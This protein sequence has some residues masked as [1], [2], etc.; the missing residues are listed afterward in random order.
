MRP[1]LLRLFFFCIIPIAISAQDSTSVVAKRTY[2]TRPLISEKPPV[3]DGTLDDEAWHLAKWAGEFIEWQP[4]ENTLPSQQ[5][6]FKIL[7]DK[8]FLYVA[9][10]CYDSEPKKIEKRLTRRD[11]FAG[12]RIAIVIDSYHDKRTAF[13]F[14]TTVAGVKGDEFVSENGNN[15][16]NSWNPIWFTATNIDSEGWTGE[17]KIP[18]SQLKFGKAEEQV[19]G[20]QV[21][22]LLFREEE[23]SVW[24]RT[25]LDAAGFVSEFGEL[26]GLLNIEPQKQLEIQPFTV[27]Q[28]DSY[29]LE[30]GNPFRD[31]SDYG[32]NV[33]LDAKIGI[34]NDLTL[35]LTVNPDFGQVDADPGAIALD[36]FQIFFQ[37]RRP[38]FVENKN[39]FDFEFANGNDNVFYS[40][41]I[42]RDP[43]GSPDLLDGE[44]SDIPG[45]TTIL[46]AAKFSGKTKNGWSVGLLESVTGKMYAEIDTDGERREELVEP[47]T[48]YLVGRLQKDFNDRN[49]YIGGI[50]TATNRSLQ[51]NLDFL[52]SAAYT[53]GFDFKHNWKDRNYYIEG[54]LV[55]SHVQGSEEAIRRTQESITHLFQRVDASHVT[56]DPTRTSLTGTGGKIEFGKAG[57]G[58]WRYEG[59]LIWRSPELELND[60][61]FLRQADEIRQYTELERL[62]L[63]PTKLYRRARIG[64][65]QFTTYDFEGNFNRIQY[66]LSGYINFMN[67]WALEGGGAHKPRIFSNTVLRGGP[68]WQWSQE[69]FAY[70]FIRSDTR[71]K[72][73]FALGYIKSQARQNNFSLTRYIMEL[74]YQPFDAFNFSLEMEYEENPNKTQY[75]TTA[76]NGDTTRYILGAIDQKTFSTSIRFNYSINPNLSIQYYGQPFISRGTYTD[77]NYV[78][79]PIAY[80]LS[81][82]VMLY[83]PNQISLSNSVYGI[84]ENIDGSVDYTFNNPD[85]AF[86]QFRSNLVVRWEYIPGSEVFFVWSQG[87]TGFG[88]PMDSLS[89]SLDDQIFGQKPENTFLI[90][91]TYRF[92]L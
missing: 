66:Q 28:F 68:R 56:V 25:P 36:G 86:V 13:S 39:I 2:T 62:F 71:K 69:N 15:W 9:Y 18:F 12:D 19:W 72:F 22:R 38:F 84:D 82:R 80:D 42:G 27:N 5:T 31:G 74:N 77:F 46:G 4:D 92:V 17:A 44:F 53:G 40:R 57:G 33:G 63:E 91:A 35:D 78:N 52:R 10:R 23:R 79:N 61:G 32:F 64:I 30:S 41:R 65:E 58:N 76:D 81:E 7:Y 16:D 54:N 85:F 29:P 11:G 24:N 88:D 20:L 73:N 87:V 60:V 83:S 89:S 45:N 49:S 21:T 67:N 8:N 47:A 34:T 75:V 90:K 14:S 6:K 51:G 59:G 50:F 70:F 1:G 3:I 43:Q 48:N 37:E 55:T 26:H